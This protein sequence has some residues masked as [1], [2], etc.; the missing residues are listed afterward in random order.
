M[1]DILTKFNPWWETS[2]QFPG[3]ARKQYLSMFHKLKS[4]KD[5]I[6]ITGL[7]RVGK[8]TLMHQFIHQL[9]QEEDP[10]KILYISLDYLTLRNHTILELEE[11]FRQM[12]SLKYNE[13][14]FLFLDEVH[15]QKDYELQLKNL[16]DL[17]YTKVFASGSANLDLI[18]K[19][20]YLTGRQRLV[21]VNPL[22][23][24]EFLEF[25]DVQL[26]MADQHLY[27]PLAAEYV[28]TGGL[29]EY[30]KS[31]DPN[32]LQALIDTIL[33]RDISGHHDIRN[34][35]NLKDILMYL[36]QTVSTPISVNRISRVLHIRHEI[37]RKVID[38]FMESNLIHVIE[39]EGNFAERKASP[40]KVYLA[41]N[42]LFT[43]L[44]ENINLGAKVENL[45]YLTLA[46]QVRVRYYKTGKEE[47][48]FVQGKQA[49]ESKFKSRISDEDVAPIKKLRGHPKKTVI[50]E[51][52]EG[53]ING[54]DLIPLWRFLLEHGEPAEH[55]PPITILH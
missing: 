36:S 6:L 32:V 55:Y 15:F 50:T 40:R 11:K 35:E 28:E 29:P 21:R 18:M 34:R 48:D 44:T 1:E 26:S 54:V 16:Y 25:K 37:V 7:R 30:I 33:Y 2:Y 38:L 14:I 51:S 22:T 9:L 41:D 17:G 39:R 53:N 13:Y 46:K 31:R 12:K 3:I 47:V 10:R 23:F 43:I 42:G 45:I 20:P 5:V 27:P 49:Y 4:I 19:S 52:K 8:T 24:Q